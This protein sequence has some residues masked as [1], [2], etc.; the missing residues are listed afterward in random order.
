MAKVAVASCHD[1]NNFGSMFQAWAT[2]LIAMR[3]A[4]DVPP[5]S[6]EVLS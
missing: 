6:H 5:S 2:E 1:K 4:L 3:V